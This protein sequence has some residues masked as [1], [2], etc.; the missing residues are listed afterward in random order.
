MPNL[1]V[2]GY[3]PTKEVRRSKTDCK[4]N[5]IKPFFLLKWKEHRNFSTFNKKIE[6]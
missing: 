3:G 2:E 4:E 5:F 6:V 1:E